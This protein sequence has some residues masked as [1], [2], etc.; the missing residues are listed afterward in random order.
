MT[1]KLFVVG[2]HMGLTKAL[3][4]PGVYSVKSSY[5]ASKKQQEKAAAQPLAI[6][7][8]WRGFAGYCLPCNRC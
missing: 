3:L 5:L 6:C 8:A 4:I 1:R 2:G 7:L